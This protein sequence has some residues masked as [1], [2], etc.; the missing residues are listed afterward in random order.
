VILARVTGRVWNERAVPGLER[1]RLVTVRPEGTDV[2]LVAVDLIHTAPPNLVLLAADEAA[3]A[4]VDGDAAGVD[5]AVVA[6]VAGA[7][8]LPGAAGP[9]RT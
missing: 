3:Q 4:A 9:E 1:R 2:S 6:L 7:D 8:E 5:L